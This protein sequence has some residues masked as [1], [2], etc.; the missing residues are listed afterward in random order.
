MRDGDMENYLQNFSEVAI[1]TEN[2]MNGADKLNGESVVAEESGN[3]IGMGGIVQMNGEYH[4]W[5]S[6]APVMRKKI[7]F[8]YRALNNALN[9]LDCYPLFVTVNNDRTRRLAIM[10]NFQPFDGDTLVRNE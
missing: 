9:A 5:V 6:L 3:V 8:L 4:A 2:C 7:I 1:Q 10:L